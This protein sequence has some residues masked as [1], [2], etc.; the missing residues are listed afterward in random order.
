[1]KRTLLLALAL[2]PL[3]VPAHPA[4][5]A[6]TVANP[7]VRAITAFVR[8]DRSAWEKQVTEALVVLRKAQHEFESAGYQVESLRITTQPVGELVAGLSEDDALAFLAQFDQLSAKE[9]FIP[10]V[11]PGMMHD[12]D[13]PA[14]LHVL[15]RALST[16]PN[17]EASTIIA[18]DS[19]IQWKTIHQSAELV[20]YVA[21]HS[22][23]AQGTFN[24]TATAMLKTLG[25][26]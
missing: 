5:P 9:N 18:D 23:R 16:L 11:G 12:E 17:I 2:L 8:L 26:F 15:E 14:P 24:F 25:P 1:M 3:Q 6:T 22:P 4:A 7:K 19:G 13:D 10:N 21:E 20:K